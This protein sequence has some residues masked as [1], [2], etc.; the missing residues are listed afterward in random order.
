[1]HKSLLVGAVGILVGA[2]APPIDE[3]K[4]NLNIT[5]SQFGPYQAYQSDT[6][7]GFKYSLGAFRDSVYEEMRVYDPVSNTQY[8]KVTKAKHDVGKYETVSVNFD[9]RLSGYF[10]Y[11]GLKIRFYIY[12]NTT[13]IYD[14]SVTIYPIEKSTVYVY[15]DNVKR[16]TSKNVAFKLGS[17]SVST[18]YDDFNFVNTN[19]FIDAD[20]YYSL[21]L[22]SLNF[23]Y[24]Q[25][26]M[27]YSSGTLSVYDPKMNLK[28]FDHVEGKV[29]L[30]IEVINK[31][32]VKGFKFKD[33]FYVDR[34]DLDTSTRY[35]PGYVLSQDFYF[36]VNKKRDFLG[37]KIE[38][39]L[40]D[41]GYNKYTLIFRVNYDVYRDLI[42]SCNESDY[43][44]KGKAS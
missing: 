18:F 3:E 37:T 5:C 4:I 34:L 20:S 30:P 11:R 24:N 39:I 27:S 22:K 35:I 17:R 9:L 14:K 40:K 36:P 23:L 10:D 1:M 43:C 7:I 29:T 42:G 2:V 25:S 21:D 28:H 19:D 31:E 12:Y 8:Y 13:S 6:T 16:L 15:E 44:V 33:S 41:C 26:A 32:E 38:I